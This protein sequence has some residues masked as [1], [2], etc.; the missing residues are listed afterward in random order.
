MP[1]RLEIGDRVRSNEGYDPLP[2]EGEVKGISVGRTRQG[3]VPILRILVDKQNGEAVPP[4]L[5]E[6]AASQWD[7]VLPDGTIEAQE[8]SPPKGELCP[9]CGEVHAPSPFTPE[10]FSLFDEFQKAT[11]LER[12]G[13]LLELADF[14]MHEVEA[15]DPEFPD[16]IHEMIEDAD[17]AQRDAERAMFRIGRMVIHNIEEIRAQNVTQGHIRKV[18]AMPFPNG[19]E[20]G[21]RRKKDGLN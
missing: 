14:F 4:H 16:G 19:P 1:D 2:H 6:S 10:M 13:I 8:K 12:P 11:P 5:H 3:P 15:T 9:S 21:G 20:G 18:V 7:K 17:D